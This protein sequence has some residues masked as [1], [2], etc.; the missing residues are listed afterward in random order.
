MVYGLVKQSG[1]A[2]IKIY[3]EDGP[4]HLHQALSSERPRAADVE[5]VGTTTAVPISERN[6]NDSLVVEDDPLVRELRDRPT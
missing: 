5:F 3:C 4:W 6:G 2:T 1:R